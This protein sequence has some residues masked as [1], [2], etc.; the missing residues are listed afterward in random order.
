[1]MCVCEKESVCLTF[2]GFIHFEQIPFMFCANVYLLSSKCSGLFGIFL[3]ITN[4][5]THLWLDYG[6]LFKLPFFI[7]F[8]L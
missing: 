5:L 8:F 1:M 7:Y 6:F 4:D 2:Y 3:L